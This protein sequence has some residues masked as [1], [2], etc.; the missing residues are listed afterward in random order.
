V[1]RSVCSGDKQL[2]DANRI[3]NRK[4]TAGMIEDSEQLRGLF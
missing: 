2:D 3:A 4:L 1:A